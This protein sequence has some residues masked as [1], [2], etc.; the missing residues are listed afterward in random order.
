MGVHVRL[1]LR[2]TQLTS[3]HSDE[4]Q[5]LLFNTANFSL[6]LFVTGDVDMTL[7]VFKDGELSEEFLTIVKKAIMMT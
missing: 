1:E 3:K 2:D 7:G 4:Q 5:M 6:I